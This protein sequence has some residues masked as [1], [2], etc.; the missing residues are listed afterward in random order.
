LASAAPGLAFVPVEH[1]YDAPGLAELWARRVRDTLSRAGPGQVVIFTAHSVPETAGGGALGYRDEVDRTAELVAAAAGLEASTT[2]WRVAFQSAGRT[3]Q[4]WLGPDL[5]STLA[6]VAASGHRGVVV[7]AV[8]FV[9]D[10]LEI[11]YDLDVEASAQAERLGIAF[12]RT[13]SLNADPLFL[14]ALGGVVE[15]AASGLP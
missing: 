11:L 5:L 2:P 3:E 15:R 4:P 7:C 1:W 10:H 13:E 9:A 14:A 8:G 6:D 12:A